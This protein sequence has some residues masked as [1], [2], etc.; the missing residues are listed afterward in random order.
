MDVLL[1]DSDAH[2]RSLWAQGLDESSWR[3]HHATTAQQAIDLLDSRAVHVIVL[4]LDIDGGGALA[5]PVYAGYRQPAA[6]VIVVTSLPM[7]RDGSI[8]GLCG[9]ACA[10]LDASAPPHDIAVLVDHHGRRASA[11]AHRSPPMLQ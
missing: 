9:N 2:R 6:R 1:V 10:F 5:V 8:F 11:A 3:V 4:N 7:F